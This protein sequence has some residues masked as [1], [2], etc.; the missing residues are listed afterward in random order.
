MNNNN[1]ENNGLD[2]QPI[3]YST[4]AIK[5]V[6]HNVFHRGLILITAALS[7]YA[8][9]AQ[10]VFVANTGSNDVSVIDAA[11]NTVIDTVPGWCPALSRRS[12]AR[13][14]AR[15]REQSRV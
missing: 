2:R 15:L 6:S 4:S 12:L 9:L 1:K 8:A 14:Q 7:S 13:W 10:S 5:A 11:S 3:P